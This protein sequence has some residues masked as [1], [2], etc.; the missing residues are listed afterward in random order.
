MP[1]LILSMDGLVLNEI[2]LDTD[3]I[4]IG[5]KPHCDVQIDNLAI[6]GEHALLRTIGE[7]AFLE[8]LNSTN[9]THVNGQSIKKCSLQDLDVVEMGKY[10]LKFLVDAKTTQSDYSDTYIDSG[11]LKSIG[12]SSSFKTNDSGEVIASSEESSKAESLQPP[13]VPAPSALPKGVLRVLSG[14]RAGNEII[15][16]NAVTR[17]GKRGEQVVSISRHPQGYFLTHIEGESPSLLNGRKIG[18]DA[19]LLKEHD[20]LDLSGIKLEFYTRA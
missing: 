4:L 8:D 9:G 20:T 3:R 10:K 7:D 1:K 11:A 5:R 2:N 17:L 14:K 15:L 18:P 13:A 6:S 19:R 16:D 12:L